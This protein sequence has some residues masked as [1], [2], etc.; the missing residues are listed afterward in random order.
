MPDEDDDKIEY[1]EVLEPHFKQVELTP[2]EAD[3][4]GIAMMNH[5]DAT[6]GLNAYIGLAKDGQ[7]YLKFPSVNGDPPTDPLLEAILNAIRWSDILLQN[8]QQQTAKAGLGFM[9]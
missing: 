7:P 3:L 5:I 1:G 2:D 4:M 6:Q 9:P 8:V